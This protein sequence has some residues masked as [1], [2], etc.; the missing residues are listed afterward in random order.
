[1]FYTWNQYKIIQKVN[2]NE[3]K[4]PDKVLMVLKSSNSYQ[5]SSGLPLPT[6]RVTSVP[7][8]TTFS[9][10]LSMLAVLDSLIS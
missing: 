1:M 7:S 4:Q 9:F 6:L 8:C 10:V 3:K 5:A 2:Y